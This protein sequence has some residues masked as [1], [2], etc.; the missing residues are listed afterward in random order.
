[1]LSKI[2]RKINNLLRV[3]VTF[4]NWLHVVGYVFSIS[5][6]SKSSK[7]KIGT[8][9]LRSGR[10]IKIRLANTF[11]LGT[12]IETHQRK[13]Y[14]PAHI[15]I[16]E[17][18]K[19]IDIGASIGDFGVFCAS[20]FKNPTVYCYEPGS[21]AFQLLKQNIQLNQLE[22]RIKP[23]NLAISDR[24]G[25]ISYG[26]EIFNAITIGQIL[27]QNKID[28]CDLLKMDIE[29]AEYTVF[30]NTPLDILSSVHAIAMECH[31]FGSDK[32]L[33]NLQSYLTKAGFS[34]NHSK[35]NAHNICYLYA[36]R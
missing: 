24:E 26:T 10:S 27:A 33:H 7:N 9:I 35:I 32:D 11:D 15:R 13:V 18:A 2:A 8:V 25:T 23:F 4:K 16:P 34:V 20:S 5:L 28:R 19:I 1:M 29:G 30:L 21:E 31:I 6:F 12:V 14:T 17:N 22:S 36:T 3:P